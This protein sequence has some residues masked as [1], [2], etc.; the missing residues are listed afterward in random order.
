[1]GESERQTCR[2]AIRAIQA[3]LLN[4]AV[5][6]HTEL[7]LPDHID[8]RIPGQDEQGFVRTRA[9]F[10]SKFPLTTHTGHELVFVMF[11]STFF[12]FVAKL[13]TKGNFPV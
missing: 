11:G 8:R 9:K 3:Q 12:Q 6:L 5:F 7:P 2:T 1:M 4:F 13:K 10:C